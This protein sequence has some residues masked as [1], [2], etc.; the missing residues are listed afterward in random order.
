MK[1]A[2]AQLRLLLSVILLIAGGA[3]AGL[4][5]QASGAGVIADV[6]TLST[7]APHKAVDHV[8]STDQDNH[9]APC[10]DCRDCVHLTGSNC[11]AAGISASECGV[12]DDA[13]VTIRLMAGKA[14]LATGIDPEAL[15]QPPRP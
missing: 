12:L 11:C 7:S 1:V 8:A 3:I 13:P 2:L 15:L 14:V 5:G 9:H 10:D 6:A 4:A